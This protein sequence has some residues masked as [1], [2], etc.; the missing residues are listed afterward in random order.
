MSNILSELE[1][2][3]ITG[4][5]KPKLQLKW[6][7]SNGFHEARLNASNRVVMSTLYFHQCLGAKIE[8]I[9]Q[10]KEQSVFNLDALEAL[11]THG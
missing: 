1:I 9:T 11:M 6:L 2:S 7:H 10:E 5:Q 3:E 4:L 8:A